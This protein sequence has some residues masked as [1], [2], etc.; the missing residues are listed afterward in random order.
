MPLASVALDSRTSLLQMLPAQRGHAGFCAPRRLLPAGS[1][2]GQRAHFIAYG[3]ETREDVV[4][5]TS[6]GWLKE[7]LWR[8]VRHLEISWAGLCVKE[9]EAWEDQAGSQHLWPERG[10]GQLGSDE[11]R[12]AQLLG[13]G[14][15]LL[16]DDE[17][18]IERRG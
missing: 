9:L 14:R 16:Q 8:R 1:R 18:H 17:I 12:F 5:E 15:V 11:W 3:E 4:T 7:R 13:A 2:A 6:V 10:R